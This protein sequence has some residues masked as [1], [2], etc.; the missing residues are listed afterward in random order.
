M[1]ADDI[2][3]IGSRAEFLDAVRTA[4]TQAAAAGAREIVAR[5]LR[6]SPTGR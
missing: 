3:P 1:T 5:R 2:A 4:F 6:T